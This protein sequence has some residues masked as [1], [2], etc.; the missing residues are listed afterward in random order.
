[1]QAKPKHF[2]T[3][4]CRKTRKDHHYEAQTLKLMLLFN[5]FTYDYKQTW[6]HAS[7]NK[8]KNYEQKLGEEAKGYVMFIA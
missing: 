3:K 1:M 5:Y 2:W 4:V 6:N 8:W 7:Y